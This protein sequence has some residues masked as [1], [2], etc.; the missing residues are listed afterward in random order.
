MTVFTK[1]CLIATLA[2]SVASAQQQESASASS[3][4]STPS[5]S[6][7]AAPSASSGTSASNG[8][9][10]TYPTDGSVP[11][12]KPEWMELLKNANITDAPVQ[13]SSGENG[14]LH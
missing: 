7:S 5:A 9:K 2:L 6:A 4:V 3:D 14:A 13:K 10:E 12:P 1:L 8:F 11:T